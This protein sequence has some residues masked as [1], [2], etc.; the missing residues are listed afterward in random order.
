MFGSTLKAVATHPFVPRRPDLTSLDDLDARCLDAL[1]EMIWWQEAPAVEIHPTY[2]L[3]GAIGKTLVDAHGIWPRLPYAAARVLA[4]ASAVPPAARLRIEDPRR[5]E[6]KSFFKDAIEKHG[7]LPAAVAR[8]PKTWIT[9]PTAEWIRHDQRPMVEAILLGSSLRRRGIFDPRTV[10]ELLAEHHSGRADHT[11]V[12]MMVVAAE[13]WLR[14]FVDP[15]SLRAPG[16]ASIASAAGAAAVLVQPRGA[17]G[18][19]A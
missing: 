17:R 19:V 5:V 3:A 8:R 10:G 7:F 13:I 6:L 15:P 9:S 14:L 4:V 11:Y 12:L 1:P 16:H 18:A 2:C